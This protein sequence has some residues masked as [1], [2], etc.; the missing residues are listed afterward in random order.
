L[1]L[2]DDVAEEN[3]HRQENEPI[4]GSRQV[5]EKAPA[6]MAREITNVAKPTLMVWLRLCLD[7]EKS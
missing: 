6:A 7:T 1:Q 2:L 4:M 5:P 3:G